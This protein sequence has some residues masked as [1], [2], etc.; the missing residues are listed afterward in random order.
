[1]TIVREIADHFGSYPVFTYRDAELYLSGKGY[2]P[3]NLVRLLAYMKGIGKLH[4]VR[5]GAYTL[6][7]DTMVAGFAYSPFYY[8]LLSALTI[9][10]LW[11]QNSKPEIITVR[12]VRRS[13]VQVFGGRDTVF[14][15][16][17]PAKYFFGFDILDYGK[18]RLPVADPEKTLIDL[19][20][21]KTKLAMQNYSGLLKAI[22]M[23]K[24]QEY[25]KAYDRRTAEVVKRF[26]KK[27]K[28]LADSGKMESPY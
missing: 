8:G 2:K 1:M 14:L 11:T 21:Y 7:N 16:H 4:E 18:L 6:S 15:H 10:G 24:L 28:S 3:R 9:R 13:K 19:F 26:A 25:L 27:Y 23:K 17:I 5:K 20:Y 12:K 22:S